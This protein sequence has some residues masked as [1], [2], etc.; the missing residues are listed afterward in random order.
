MNDPAASSRSL[1]L[2][3]LDIGRVLADRDGVTFRAQGTCMYPVVRPGDV[4]RIQSCRAADVA[5]GNIA[6]CRGP[7]YLFSHRV[8]YKG[9]RDGRDFIIT[10]P[11]RSSGGGDAPIFDENLLGVVLTIQRDGRPVPLAPAAYPWPTRG[12]FRVRLALI[13]AAPRLYRWLLK[14]TAVVQRQTLYHSVARRWFAMSRPRLAYRVSVPLNAAL[15]DT[16]VRQ[17]PLAEFDPEAP[18]QGRPIEHWTLALLINDGQAPAAWIILKRE[19][20]GAWH[21]EHQGVRIRYG[22]LGLEQ[23]LVQQ[24]RPLARI[25]LDPSGDQG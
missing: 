2:A 12:Y 14:S 1:I 20:G 17:L 10:R 4:L 6:V 21:I 18:W 16:V 24:A 8:I 15:G 13:E 25:E 11:D 7:D 9:Q 5:V 22:G 23:L 19:A 3:S